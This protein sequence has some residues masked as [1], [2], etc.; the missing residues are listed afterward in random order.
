MS[1]SLKGNYITVFST[2]F[3]YRYNVLLTELQALR[4]A[5]STKTKIKNVH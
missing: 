5:T 4:H 1:V 2:K 3:S